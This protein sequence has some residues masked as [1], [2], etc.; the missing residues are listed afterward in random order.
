VREGDTVRCVAL[1]P[2]AGPLSS[3]DAS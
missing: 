3:E 2:E 1:H